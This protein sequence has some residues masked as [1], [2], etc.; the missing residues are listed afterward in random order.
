MYSIITVTVRRIILLCD[1][2][3][4]I[5]SVMSCEA[6]RCTDHRASRH[7]AAYSKEKRNAH[8][9]KHMLSTIAMSSMLPAGC[10]PA[11][12]TCTCVW[13]GLTMQSYEPDTF[14]CAC[15]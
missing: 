7:V 2:V 3:C 5:K 12:Y 13:G 4:H 6:A 11:S 8:C 1:C 15:S 10:L 9:T 14:T